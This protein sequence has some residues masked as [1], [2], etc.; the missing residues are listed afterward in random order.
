MKIFDS[1][2]IRN[3]PL[4][5]KRVQEMAHDV[6]WIEGYFPNVFFGSQVTCNSYLIKDGRNL[7]LIDNGRNP[8]YQEKLLALIN[9]YKGQVDRLYMTLT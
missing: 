7:V 9:T 4:L 1:M 2:L 5:L 8:V 6:W 3:D